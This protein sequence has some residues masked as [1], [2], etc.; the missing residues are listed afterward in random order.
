M[1]LKQR[2]SELRLI[3]AKKLLKMAAASRDDDEIHRAV[4]ARIANP[5]GE[6]E[7]E[8]LLSL[9]REKQSEELFNIFIAQFNMDYSRDIDKNTEPEIMLQAW[10]K[11]SERDHDFMMRC[12]AFIK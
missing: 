10:I 5:E 3:N 9:S 11:L 6:S 4:V 1:Q 8:K 12:Q 2:D 7:W